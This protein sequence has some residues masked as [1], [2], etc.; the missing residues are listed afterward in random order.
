M[1]RCVNREGNAFWPMKGR[2]AWWGG[3]SACQKD[4][5]QKNSP[6]T[7]AIYGWRESCFEEERRLVWWFSSRDRDLVSICGDRGATRT[8]RKLM[9]LFY[10]PQGKGSP[11]P[12]SWLVGTAENTPTTFWDLLS[13]TQRKRLDYCFLVLPTTTRRISWHIF[14]SNHMAPLVFLMVPSISQVIKKSFTG[15]WL[16]CSTGFD[17]QTFVELMSE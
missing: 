5:V 8:M 12:L 7:R 13:E 6:P 1:V 17:Q 14:E 4:S 10:K 2:T 11:T 3:N 9:W 16:I 15:Q